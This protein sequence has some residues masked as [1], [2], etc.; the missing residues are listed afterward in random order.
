M[1]NAAGDLAFNVSNNSEAM[2]IDS[3]GKVG[4]GRTAMNAPLHIAAV[5]SSFEE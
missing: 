5:Y 3:S 2:R 1:R 4:I